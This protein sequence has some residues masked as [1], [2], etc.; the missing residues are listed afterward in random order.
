MNFREI[1]NTAGR[2][3]SSGDFFS[4]IV[5]RLKSNMIMSI[6]MLLVTIGLLGVVFLFILFVVLK[7]L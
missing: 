5:N 2:S 4:R 6:V 3:S 1:V 7:S